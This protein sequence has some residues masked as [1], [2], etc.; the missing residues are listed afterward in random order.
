MKKAHSGKYLLH[1]DSICVISLD[2][3]LLD[4]VSVEKSLT[5]PVSL[6]TIELNR[7]ER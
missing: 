2:T 3:S 4:L 6:S 7:V 1:H 5:P